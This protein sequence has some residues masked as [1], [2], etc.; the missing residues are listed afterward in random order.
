MLMHFYTS[1]IRI[2][3]SDDIFMLTRAGIVAL[4]ILVVVL[5]AG[6]IIVLSV[7]GSNSTSAPA[8]A[9]SVTKLEQNCGIHRDILYFPRDATEEGDAEFKSFINGNGTLVA[10]ARGK[11]WY[12]VA[13][14]DSSSGPI[15]N[16]A[17][18]MNGEAYLYERLS[19]ERTTA[20]LFIGNRLLHATK[21]T[22]DAR[23]SKPSLCRS[24]DNVL[25]VFTCASRGLLSLRSTDAGATWSLPVVLVPDA[26]AF[27][28]CVIRDV[29]S[30][31]K[32]HLFYFVTDVLPARKLR[33]IK[34][35]EEINMYYS[36]SND[37]G[38]RFITVSTRV[39]GP[40]AE[41][42]SVMPRLV[43]KMIRPDQVQLDF[44]VPATVIDVS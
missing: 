16:G 12:Q 43:A 10:M 4:V 5:L 28:P 22:V 41:F 9:A 27:G 6:I 35:T 38:Q 39:A 11:D 3:K 7:N 44:P 2:T 30:P 36:Y 17:I 14:H 42:P 15:V 8:P 1:A 33:R 34:A 24:G 26:T 40:L 20:E 23:R 29:Y 19:K 31:K 13:T 32:V 37:D 21:M 25:I 18:F